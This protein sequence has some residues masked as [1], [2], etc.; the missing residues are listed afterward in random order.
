M[1]VGWNRQQSLARGGRHHP[2]PRQDVAVP[3]MTSEVPDLGAPLAG[4]PGAAYQAFERAGV[5]I[6]VPID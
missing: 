1:G 3:A 4:A 5:V 6:A 2:V